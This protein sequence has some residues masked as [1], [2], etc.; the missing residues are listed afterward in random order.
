MLPCH[1][2][3]SAD[4]GYVSCAVGRMCRFRTVHALRHTAGM[5]MRHEQADLVLVAEHL[6]H[7]SLDTVRGTRTRIIAGSTQA[8]GGDLVIKRYIGVLVFNTSGWN[9]SS[10][11]VGPSN[12]LTLTLPSSSV[13]S[14]VI[15]GPPDLSLTVSPTFQVCMA[16][17]Y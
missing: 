12:H 5:R 16:R 17:V 4:S 6:R 10:R 8:G 3:R 7:A 13:S 11:R 1:R 2:R 15:I 9:I 14:T